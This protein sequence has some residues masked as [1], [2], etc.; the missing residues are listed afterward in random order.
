MSKVIERCVAEQLTSHLNNSPFRLHPM[1]FGFRSNHST[2]TANCSLLE[3]VEAKLNK[4]GVVGAI[5]LDLKKAF[6]T[7]D[8]DVLLA[9]LSMFNFSPNAIKQ[10]QSYL[11][12]RTQRVKINGELSSALSCDIGVPQGSILGPLLFSLYINYCMQ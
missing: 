12:G 2:E 5:F 4:G 8:H 7:V 3:N 1:Q 9:K 6:D 11:E 10:I